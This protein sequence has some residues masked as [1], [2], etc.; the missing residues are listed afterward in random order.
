MES[1]SN[2]IPSNDIISNDIKDRMIEKILAK[3][4]HDNKLQYLVKWQNF[5]D[6]QN[7]WEDINKL[8]NIENYTNFIKQFDINTK[9]LKKR[10]RPKKNDVDEKNKNLLDLN[11]IF[12]NGNQEHNI[13]LNDEEN[14]EELLLLKKKKRPDFK[15]IN[16]L[17]VIKDNTKY[18][19][20]VEKKYDDGKTKKEYI[21]RDEFSKVRLDQYLDFKS[22]I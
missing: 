5:P 16:I 6:N 19:L 4:K 3:R 20:L 12:S 18:K 11:E 22:S 1:A 2:D 7:S 13:Q 8:K 15:V 17:G 21:N 10:G 14:D 9:K